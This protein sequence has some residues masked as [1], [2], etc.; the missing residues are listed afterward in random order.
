MDDH[1]PRCPACRYRLD[2]ETDRWSSQCPLRGK[3]PECG[4]DFDWRTVLGPGSRVP[5][6]FDV[7]GVRRV[8]FVR[9]WR[10]TL[11][12]LTPSSFWRHMADKPLVP[13]RLGLWFAMLLVRFHLVMVC[14]MVFRSREHVFHSWW[15]NTGTFMEMALAPHYDQG[16]MTKS[17][18]VAPVYFG[19]RLR[20]GLACGSIL[21]GGALWCMARFLGGTK[22]P[23]LQRAVVYGLLPVAFL[24]ALV[25]S[26]SAV[27]IVGDLFG[28][29][30]QWWLGRQSANGWIPGVS[31]WFRRSADVL[32]VLWVGAWWWHASGAAM[33]RPRVPVRLLATAV[34]VATGVVLY[35]IHL[36][37]W[38]YASW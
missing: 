25:L 26:M 20:I 24:Y 2:G 36:N 9:W 15:L 34:A 4:E 10:T 38:M 31:M 16:E 30:M 35:A 28:Q 29:P 17:G 3:C 12:L 21:A 13:S 14:V 6:A 37:T 32:S 22:L 33:M 5:W 23:S 27:Q 7:P 1:S 18:G 11:R 19:D 8:A